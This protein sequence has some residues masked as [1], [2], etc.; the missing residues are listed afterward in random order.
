MPVSALRFISPAL[1]RTASTP[2][3]ASFARLELGVVA[4]SSNRSM[5]IASH[6][7]LRIIAGELRGRKL[8][9]VPGLATRPTADR[10]RE[11]IFNILGPGTRGAHVLDLFAGTGAFGIEA[12]SRGAVSAV[13]IEMGREAHAVLSRN[14]QGCGLAERA[15]VIRWD[16]AR[17]LD[18]LRNRKAVFRL[19]FMDPPYGQGLVAPALSHLHAA[20]CLARGARLVVEHGVGDPLPETGDAYRLQDLRRYGKTLVSFLSYVI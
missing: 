2:R 6:M 12:L 8:R 9:T 16:A 5:G 17:N 20:R 19:V 14:I 3:A 15:A 13:F 10:T 1:R 11:A 7:T 18:C 4:K